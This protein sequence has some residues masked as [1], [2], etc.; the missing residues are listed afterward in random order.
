[1]TKLRTVTAITK[2]ILEHYPQTRSCDALLWLKV[3]EHQAHAKGIDLR[4]LSVPVFLTDM[5]QMGFVPFETCRRARQKIQANYP[6]LAASDRV[7]HFR[8]KN[9]AEYRKYALQKGV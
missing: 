3:L 4:I 8:K 9:E 5:R 7:E 1:M 2:E 6:E